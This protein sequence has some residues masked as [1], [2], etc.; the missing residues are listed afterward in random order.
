MSKKLKYLK[1]ENLKQLDTFIQESL[2][3]YFYVDTWDKLYSNTGNDHHDIISDKS[4]IPDLVI[5]N[6]PFDKRDCFLK[7]NKKSEYIEFPRF[8]FLLRPKKVEFYNP[9]GTYNEDEIEE[10]KKQE[11]KNQ[12][13]VLVNGDETKIKIENGSNNKEV[14]IN[15]EQNKEK[16]NG[17]NQYKNQKK[18]KEKKKQINKDPNFY[19]NK[20]GAP[21]NINCWNIDNNDVDI[22]IHKDK[23]PK[24]MLFLY[25]QNYLNPKSINNLVPDNNKEQKLKNPSSKENSKEKMPNNHNILEKK[26]FIEQQNNKPNV[27]SYYK[28]N[29]KKKDFKKNRSHTD[30]ICIKNINKSGWKVVNNKDNSFVNNFKSQDLYYFLNYINNINKLNDYSVCDSDSDFFFNPIDVYE[31]LKEMFQK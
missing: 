19:N 12:N 29:R 2:D 6:K 15:S 18:G 25:Y 8:Q 5:Y 27:I 22:N 16:D 4:V 13:T 7:Y 20:F 21:D 24:N 14:A 17:N 28:N 11:N 30:K 1:D 10:D 23:K 9:S 26:N 31:K 3:K